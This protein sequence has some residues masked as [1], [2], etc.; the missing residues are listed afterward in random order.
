MFKPNKSIIGKSVCDHPIAS[1]IGG[2]L[3][4]VFFLATQCI[5]LV[6]IYNNIANIDGF[7]GPE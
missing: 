3:D 2:I 1:T 7:M 5:I 6:P 4:T